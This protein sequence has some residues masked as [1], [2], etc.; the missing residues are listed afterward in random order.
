VIS[1]IDSP[2][3]FAAESRSHKK[4]PNTYKH[5]KLDGQQT[6]IQTEKVYGGSST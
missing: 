5:K 6:E 3:L 2:R 1:K 4:E